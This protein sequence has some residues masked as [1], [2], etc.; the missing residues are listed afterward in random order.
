MDNLK[1]KIAVSF[2]VVMIFLLSCMV[3]KAS[4]DDFF[5]IRDTSDKEELAAIRN[6]RIKQI[7]FYRSMSSIRNPSTLSALTN[8]RWH[9]SGYG[10]KPFILDGDLNMPIPIRG[11][12]IGNLLNA[13]H[14]IPRFQ[15]RIFANDVDFPY[16]VGDKSNPVRTPS[17]M[18]G[19]AWYMTH[20]DHWDSSHYATDTDKND[21]YWGLYAYHHSNGQDGSELDTTDD[22]VIRV[23]LY[24]GNFG[25]QVVFEPTIGGRV[26]FPSRIYRCDE[27]AK[28]SGDLVDHRESVTQIFY[29]Q[30]SYEW[31]PDA[32]TNSTYDDHDI[33]GKNRVKMMLNFIR[34]N[35]EFENLYDGKDYERVT[36]E[37]FYEKVRLVFNTSYIAD[38]NYK[39]GDI[40]D[41]RDVSLW[42][43]SK[44]LNVDL[45]AHYIPDWTKNMA[46]FLK[47]GYTGSDEYNV[48][49]QDSYVH[50]KFG[51]SFTFFDQPETQRLDYARHRLFKKNYSL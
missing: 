38:A 51:V 49:F 35:T 1:S 33:Y 25:E 45:S 7:D 37:S 42:N 31:R 50:Y 34:L 43:I 13:F 11:P 29:W 23:N 8:Y 17:A 3:S 20:R 30:L 41:L 36:N 32:W 19:F 44:R 12:V 47:A 40:T 28:S 46:F 10:K 9:T 2:S 14:V 18:P 26:V 5:A 39:S 15:F 16:R 21:L 48:Y 4:A 27:E 24:N 22:G 6:L